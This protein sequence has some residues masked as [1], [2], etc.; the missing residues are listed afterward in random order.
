MTD[1]LILQKFEGI[2]TAGE[3]YRFN[4][5]EVIDDIRVPTVQLALSGLAFIPY[6]AASMAATVARFNEQFGAVDPDQGLAEM[7]LA[8]GLGGGATLS[9]IVNPNGVVTAIRGDHYRDT[10]AAQWYICDSTPSGTAWTV[11]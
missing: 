7:L 6:V 9:G 2:D 1:Q 5:G 8:D 11:V 3:T 10:A 4:P